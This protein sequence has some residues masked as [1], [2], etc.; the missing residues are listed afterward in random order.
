MD[1]IHSSLVQVFKDLLNSVLRNMQ[2]L[3]YVKTTYYLNDELV[4]DDLK[5]GIQIVVKPN[6]NIQG[7]P[8]KLSPFWKLIFNII[9]NC[10]TLSIGDSSQ[11]KNLS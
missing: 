1:F 3:G 10:R 7:I 5:S 11:I 4:I 8:E 9:N 2:L 6:Y